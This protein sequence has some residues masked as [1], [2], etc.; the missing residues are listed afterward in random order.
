MEDLGYQIKECEFH[1]VLSGESFQGFKQ[2]TMWLDLQIRKITQAAVYMMDGDLCARI[3][4]GRLV[5]KQI[6]TVQA[7]DNKGQN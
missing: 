5:T 4:S 7:K 3:E 6:V 2:G 1:S